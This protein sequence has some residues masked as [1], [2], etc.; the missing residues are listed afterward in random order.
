MTVSL[1]P[2]KILNF[3]FGR[4]HSRPGSHD[5]VTRPAREN[6]RPSGKEPTG[7]AELETRLDESFFCF[8]PPVPLDTERL[9]D[10][11]LFHFH[12]EEEPIRPSAC[13]CQL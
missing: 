9:S 12:G 2:L 3:C 7:W 4:A 10:G 13:H 5:L 1:F 8:F 6:V 11:R